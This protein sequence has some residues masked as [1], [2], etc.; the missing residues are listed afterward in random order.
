MGKLNPGWM[1]PGTVRLESAAGSVVPDRRVER[2]DE[3][4]LEQIDSR[5]KLVTKSSS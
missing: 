3:G 1:Q 5:K 4:E 2:L